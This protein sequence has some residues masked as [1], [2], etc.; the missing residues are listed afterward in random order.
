MAAN[1]NRSGLLHAMKLEERRRMLK[2]GRKQRSFYLTK[3]TQIE[4]DINNQSWE[5][6]YKKNMNKLAVMIL[7]FV[8]FEDDDKLSRVEYRRIR[9]FFRKHTSYLDK[10]DFKDIEKF[11]ETKVKK[12]DLINYMDQHGYESSIFNEAA[13]E[14]VPIVRDSGKYMLIIYELRKDYEQQWFKAKII[15]GFFKY[16]IR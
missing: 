8:F 6:V 7:L 5:D 10:K 12:Q 1:R 13:D 2:E 9:K 14:V 3:K 15:L 16:M 4:D 11:F